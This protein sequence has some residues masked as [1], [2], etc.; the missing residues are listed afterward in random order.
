MLI[1]PII[2]DDSYWRKGLFFNIGNVC[3]TE[4]DREIDYGFYSIGISS[5][6][7]CKE[8]GMILNHVPKTIGIYGI[9]T[10]SG[11]ASMIEKEIIINPKLLQF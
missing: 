11:I 9:A 3:L 10:I 8:D 6:S 2:V 1:N 5:G 4:L 7:F